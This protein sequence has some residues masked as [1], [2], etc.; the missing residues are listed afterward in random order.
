[1]FQSKLGACSLRNPSPLGF[2]RQFLVEQDGEHKDHFDLK[3]RAI[4]PVTDA[5]R[6]LALHYQII[7][8]NNTAERFEKLAELMPEDQELYYSCAYASKAL[9][10]FRTKHGLR[11][12]NSG[13]FIALA[14][15][16]KEEKMKLKRCF[17]AVAKVQ[18]LVK[19][20]F[21]LKNFI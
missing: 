18:E 16:S 19:L 8:I 4:M 10:K 2:F 9:L 14:E 12:H 7:N 20:K 6:L 13:R 3:K 11:H 17:K 1:M 21:N 15:L 5:G